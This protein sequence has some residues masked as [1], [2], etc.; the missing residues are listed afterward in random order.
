MQ[1]GTVVGPGQSLGQKATTKCSSLPGTLQS[2]HISTRIHR[3]D[4]R[5]RSLLERKQEGNVFARGEEGRHQCKSPHHA[6][7]PFSC[8]CPNVYVS[9]T[10]L[11]CQCLHGSSTPGFPWAWSGILQYVG[12]TCL[13]P[14]WH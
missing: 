10:L 8:S 9:M 11:L 7:S 2:S 6:Y 3:P 1:Q 4:V 5:G 13:Q 12:T 14:R